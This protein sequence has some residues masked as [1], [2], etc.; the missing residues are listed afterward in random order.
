MDLNRTQISNF[1]NSAY[2]TDTL[3]IQAEQITGYITLLIFILGVIAGC[4]QAL[5]K[6]LPP[7]G[8]RRQT[9]DISL[10]DQSIDRK[11]TTV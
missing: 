3:L 5:T 1:T 2:S 11:V 4:L 9:F 10:L 6:G 7:I 8:Q